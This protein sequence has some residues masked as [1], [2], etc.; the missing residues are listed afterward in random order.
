MH[1]VTFSVPHANSQ[2]VTSSEFVG[3]GF[4]RSSFSDEALS[5]LLGFRGGWAS[6]YLIHEAKLV[7]FSTEK[8]AC[9][10]IAEFASLILN[11]RWSRH[12]LRAEEGVWPHRRPPRFCRFRR[13][14]SCP[15]RGTKRPSRRRGRHRQGGPSPPSCPRRCRQKH[16]RRD[17]DMG[18]TRY[19]AGRGGTE[20]KTV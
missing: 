2:P 4:L 11:K 20:T 17:T 12:P 7:L 9:T 18:A 1:N 13:H 16:Q 5:S 10:S 15:S 14:T 19:L 3:N 8:A 6:P